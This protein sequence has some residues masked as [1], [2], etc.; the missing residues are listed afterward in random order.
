MTSKTIFV[1]IFAV[2]ALVA[3]MVTGVSAAATNEHVTINDLEVNG[4]DALGGVD[5]AE[6][7]GNSVPVRVQFVADSLPGAVSEDVRVKAWI[8]GASG[9]S[10]VTERFDVL[11]DRTYSR[12]LSVVI[13]NDLD[14]D[15]LEEGLTLNV[16][17]ESKD[18]GTLSQV[19]VD[20][21]VQRE[22][23]VLNVLDV[24]MQSEI[25]A[26]NVL[27]LDVVL[28]NMGRKL[29]DDAFVVARIPALNVE[30][31]A[32][33]GDLSAVDQSHPDK[34]NTNERRL[35]LRVPSNAPA[36][37]YVVEIEAYNEDS[38]TTLTRKVVV[39]G[40]SAD[41]LIVSP[42]ASKLFAVGEETQYSVTLVNTGSRVQVYEFVVDSTSGLRVSADEPVVAVPAGTSKTVMFTAVAD[43]QGKHSFAV[44]VH[45]GSELV[46][47]LNF[48]A[49][50]EG[51]RVTGD[52]TVI[53]T[54]ILAIVFVVLLV[55]L[56]V[57]L[58]R[59]PEK[60]EE[61]GESYY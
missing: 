47:T 6:F 56:I 30:D 58:T 18:D 9:N 10:A 31:R 5:L 36:G 20:L 33:F 21:T 37:I 61:F 16:I 2:F 53:L 19:K 22:S 7:Y 48:S 44:N 54:V 24:D 45:S 1:S 4:V 34:E 25:S 55:V 39:N 13:P 42:L 32:Y 38:I 14:D 23:Y 3:L 12:T 51:G 60:S 50:V 26:G 15:E 43:S 17:V 46:K 8:S 35:T 57:L 52:A 11:Q 27:N 29:A 59:Q 49:N 41:T 40:A 28:K